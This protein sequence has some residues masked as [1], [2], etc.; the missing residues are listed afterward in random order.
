MR[1]LVGF[2]VAVA[3]IGCAPPHR[4]VQS[5]E[6][7]GDHFEY[8]ADWPA[9]PG[10]GAFF[11][12]TFGG[13]AF[14]SQSFRGP[15]REND[16]VLLRSNRDRPSVTWI[17]HATTLLQ[18]GGVSIL[19]DPIFGE[20]ISILFQR[21]AP[22]GVALAALPPI[23]AVVI[24]HSHR[25]HLDEDSV[26]AIGARWPRVEF[27]VPLGLADWFRARGLARVVE[28][29]WW[30]S[31]EVVGRD[32]ARA[33]VTLVPAQ[34]WSQRGPFDQNW[35]LWGGYVIDA[36]GTRFYFAGDTGYPAAFK[37]I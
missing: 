25:D 22:P 12:W 15:Y 31:T 16:G 23:D 28:L 13:R 5:P 10:I 34:H 36:A 17:G 19:T 3:A 20:R 11:K 7:R 6:W 1:A 37:E 32:G 27:I 18:A 2:A 21:K 4:Y 30:Q 35:S 8:P 26:R 29:E 14:P 33:T 24:S 9:R